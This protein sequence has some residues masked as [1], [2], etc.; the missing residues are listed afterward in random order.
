MKRKSKRIA[1][2]TLVI[3]MMTGCTAMEELLE[4]EK[5]IPL[6]EVPA[7]ALAA[8]R[9]AVAGIVLTEA[10]MEKEGGQVI[11]EIEGNANGSEYEI[12]V[13]AEGEVLEVEESS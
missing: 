10:E 5:A 3:V 2:A 12:E 6:S 4:G 13:T 11:Y 8:A 1:L 9:A 7:P